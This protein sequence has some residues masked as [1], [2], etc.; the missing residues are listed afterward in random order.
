MKKIFLV[1][2]LIVSA[3]FVT[4]CEVDNNDFESE[5]GSTIGF[6]IPDQDVSI[7]PG[8]T[9]NF[10]VA[11]FVTSVSTEDRTFALEVVAEETEITADNYSF[12]SEVVIPAGERR[13][14]TFFAL[15][16]NSLPEEFGTL[17]I[18][19]ASTANTTSGKRAT[20][21]LKSN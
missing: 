14:S 11:Y 21:N 19:F 1:L 10:P 16:N 3:A 2:T 7:N 8:Q 5:R 6:T 15:T 4:S 20:F 12:E 18:Q 17:V 13:G 9:I